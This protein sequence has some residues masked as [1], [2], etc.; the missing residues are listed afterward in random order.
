MLIN[1]SN[2]PVSTWNNKQLEAAVCQ[3]GEIV[4]IH[5]PVI[6]PD[7]GERE[8][9]LLAEEY[10][11]IIEAKLGELPC[12]DNE[13]AVHLMGEMTFCYALIDRLDKSKLNF[14]ASTTERNTSENGY[15]EKTVKFNFVR[16]RKYASYYEDRGK[17]PD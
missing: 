13:N 12:G 16:F 5:F 9:C 6:P 11:G 7:A 2:H 8:I 4:D 1:L 14:Y 10:A 17:S 3:F 15:G